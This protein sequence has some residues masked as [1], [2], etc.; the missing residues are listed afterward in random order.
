MIR[1]FNL[2]EWQLSFSAFSS[3]SL[4]LS[5][6]GLF[7]GKTAITICLFQQYRKWRGEKRGGAEV[8]KGAGRSLAF[9]SGYSLSL[10]HPLSYLSTRQLRSWQTSQIN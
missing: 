4:S 1:I 5:L 2:F 6:L 7:L 9:T 8:A 10:T 3:L